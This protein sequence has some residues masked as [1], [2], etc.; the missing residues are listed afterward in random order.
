[1][2]GLWVPVCVGPGVLHRRRCGFFV[3]GQWVRPCLAYPCAYE[4]SLGSQ[5]PPRS[6][7]STSLQKAAAAWSLGLELTVAPGAVPASRSSGFSGNRL[8]CEGLGSAHETP[9]GSTHCPLGSVGAHQAGSLRRSDGN[10][11]A[12]GASSRVLGAP[13]RGSRG[14]RALL[15]QGPEGCQAGVAQESLSEWLFPGTPVRPGRS[16]GRRAPSAAAPLP[17]VRG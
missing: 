12:R 7:V 15:P 5:P 6:A 10:G 16:F 4:A 8:T 11:R 14:T 17:R 9:L 3:A 1:M 2:P 13:V